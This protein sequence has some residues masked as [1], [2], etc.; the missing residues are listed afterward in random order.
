[1]GR[2]IVITTFGTL[3]DLNPYIALAQGLKERGHRATIAVSEFHRELIE[4]AG[5]EASMEGN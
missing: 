1:M 5:I 4:S 2:N 3:G